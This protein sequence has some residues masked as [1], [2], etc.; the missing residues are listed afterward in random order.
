MIP[1]ALKRRMPDCPAFRISPHDTNYMAIVFDP[2]D[3]GCDLVAVVEIFD[4]DGR[5]PPNLHH[6]ATEFFFVLHGHGR[7]S[8]GGQWTE[9]ARGDALMV[10]RGSEHV[11]ENTGP[12]RLYCLTIMVPDENFASA[13]RHGTPVTL[14]DDDRRVLDGL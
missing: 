13:I 7:A 5:T 12:E 1:S 3:E 6:A 11:I 2:R 14:D 8:V 4:R 10:R 9:L